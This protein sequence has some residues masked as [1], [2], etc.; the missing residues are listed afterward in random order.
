MMT[1]EELKIRCEKEGF[2]Y[3]YGPFKEEVESP[4][5][6][7][8]A[9][10]T[11]T[12]GADDTAYFSTTEIALVLTYKEKNI[13]KEKIIEENILQDIFWRKSDE[14]YLKD[15]KVWQICY[16]FKILNNGGN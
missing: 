10:D 3:S 12:F 2:K 11:D 8:I 6:V 9:Q 16:F 7:A 1:L 5:L 14:A 4:Y 13:E 15:E